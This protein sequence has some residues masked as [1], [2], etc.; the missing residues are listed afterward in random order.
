MSR[1]NFKFKDLVDIPAFGEMLGR[2]Y[3]ILHIPSAIID[4]EGNVLTGVGWQRIC[5]DF[6]RKNPAAEKLCIKS[7][8]CI[9]GKI[10]TGKPFVI[11][12]CPHGLIDSCC[13]IIIEGKHIANLFTGQILHA[14]LNDETR[15]RFRL[16]AQQ[17][18]FNE[19]DYLDALSEVPVF[20]IEKHESILDFLSQMAKMI[21]DKNK[22]F[23]G[24]DNIKDITERKLVKERLGKKKDFLEKL[25]NSLGEA[26]FTVKLPER[27]VDFV[28]PAIETIFGYSQEECIGM[29]TSMF[30]PSQQ[31]YIDFGRK[32][33]QAIVQQQQILITEQMLKRKNDELFPSEITTTFISQ[34]NNVVRVISIIRDITESKEAEKNLVRAKEEWE[35]TFNAINDIVSLQDTSM[36]IVKINQKGCDTLDLPIENIIGKYCYELFHGSKEPCT[37]CPI[38]FS[39]KT[40]EPYTKEM[41]HEK[42]GKTFLVS[43][44]PVLDDQGK[45]THITH[46]AKD[47]TEKKKLEEGLLKVQKMEA[48]GIL[49]GGIA[50]DFNN[51]LSTML[52]YS[53]MAKDGLPEESQPVKDI[54]NV[55][56]AGYRAKDLVKRILTFSRQAE[57]ELI[58]LKIQ[59]VV[60]ETLDLLRSI[61]PSTIQINQDINNSCGPVF[62]D[63]TQ[64]HQ[65][66]MNLCINAK[67]AMEKNGGVL[68]IGVDTVDVLQSTID[69]DGLDIIPGAY[70][71]LA[72]SDTGHGMSTSVMD[73]M[74]DPF[75]TTKGIGEGTGLGLAVIHG[76]MKSYNGFLKVSSELGKGS[77][78]SIYLRQIDSEIQPEEALSVSLLEKENLP[79]GT[80]TVL[81]V[82]DEEILTAMLTRILSSLGYSVT[83][84]GSSLEALQEF[85]AQPDRYD[86]VVTDMSMPQISGETLALEI[87][88]IR[89]DTPIILCTGYSNKI[90]EDEA[91]S[92]GISGYLAKPVIKIE[93]A[94]LVR[95]VLDRKKNE[96]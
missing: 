34:D 24:I 84:I 75:Y 18:G 82:D 43:A 88:S 22:D 52:G 65:A 7:D 78:F 15:D 13:P 51:I 85:K 48:I 53:E 1:T 45:L 56:K 59:D 94:Q 5:L 57:Q 81:V 86:L 71:K 93:L 63:P 64:I 42:L 38:L 21:G 67:H 69:K 19:N 73:R 14:P 2:L 87:M 90:A 32:I 62:A 60:K 50:H 70:V 74:F 76:I 10:E 28:N 40:F 80:E 26:I 27:V 66:I 83:P 95:E 58:P 6:H 12:E 23:S 3:G 68:T 16:Q 11:Y 96:D 25:T 39:Q 61:I 54:Q 8:T 35:K 17:Y 9:R 77:I 41:I 30:Y 31:E 89:P 20:S 37:E 33:K 91:R 29:Q 36:R 4:I 47:I 72:V 49:A 44:A 55:I 92:I 46:V 79:R